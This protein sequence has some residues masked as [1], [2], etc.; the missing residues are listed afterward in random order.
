MF[1][2]RERI[3]EQHDPR[4]ACDA[5]QNRGF[6]VHHRTHAE[7]R[8]MMLVQHDRVE[9]DLLG[10]A[11]FVDILVVEFRAYFRIVEG[12]RHAEEAAVLDNLVFGHIFVGALSEMHNMHGYFSFSSRYI[13]AQARKSWTNL[14]NSADFSISGRW[15]HLSKI[16]KL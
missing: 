1:Q 9:A 14:M 8:P 7:G 2:Y 10:V 11:S 3:A 12:I 16:I 15:P 13:R 6:D 5:R 4:F